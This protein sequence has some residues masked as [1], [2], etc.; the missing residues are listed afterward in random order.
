[1]E[2]FAEIGSLPQQSGV[3]LSNNALHFLQLMLVEMPDGALGLVAVTPP[4]PCFSF[5]ELAEVDAM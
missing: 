3:N 1:M 2:H 5:V 4:E